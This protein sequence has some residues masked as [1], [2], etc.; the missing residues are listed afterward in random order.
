MAIDFFEKEVKRLQERFNATF[1]QEQTVNMRA[2]YLVI[3]AICRAGML[4]RSARETSDEKRIGE[5]TREFCSVREAVNMCFDLIE[6][7][8]ERRIYAETKN[9]ERVSASG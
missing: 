5:M 2:R 7:Q 9:R 4:A 3:L 8:Q 1:G 6:P